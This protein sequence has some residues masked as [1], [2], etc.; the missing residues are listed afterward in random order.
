MFQ[1]NEEPQYLCDLWW[2][3]YGEKWIFNALFF[4]SHIMFWADGSSLARRIL[5]SAQITAETTVINF[6]I[7]YLIRRQSEIGSDKTDY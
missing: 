2:Q 1:R 5:F 7:I 6:V 4:A 3:V